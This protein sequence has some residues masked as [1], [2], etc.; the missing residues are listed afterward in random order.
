LGR[1]LRGKSYS[2]NTCHERRAYRVPGR[3]HLEFSKNGVNQ[4]MH[5][6]VV[7]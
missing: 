6:P 1:G 7:R 4:K 2:G 5:V 3:F